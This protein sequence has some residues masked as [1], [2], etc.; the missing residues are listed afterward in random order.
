[1]TSSY[2]SGKLYTTKRKYSPISDPASVMF[3]K[4]TKKKDLLDSHRSFNTAL[5]RNLE[6]W[7]HIELTSTSNA[8]VCDGYYEGRS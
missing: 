1:M 5:I 8:I 7:F 3:S 2:F 4:L 6:E